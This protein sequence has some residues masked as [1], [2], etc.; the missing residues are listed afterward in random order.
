MHIRKLVTDLQSQGLRADSKFL[1]RNGG[2]GPAQGKFFDLNGVAVN[3]PMAGPYISNSE[4]YLRYH[5]DQ[6]AIVQQGRE[7]GLIKEIP[8]PG[9]YDYQTQEGIAYNKIALLHGRDCLASTVEQTCRHWLQDKQCAFCAIQTSLACN[10][11]TATKTPAQLA[12]VAQAAQALDEVTHVVL[13]TGAGNPAGNEI[14]QLI[15]AVQAVKASTM[16]P[17][18]VQFL[19]PADLSLL[20][21][22]KAV[23]VDTVG[24]HIES[25]DLHTLHR[26]AP[27]KAEIGFNRY[28]SAWQKAVHVFGANQVSSFLLVGLGEPAQSVVE[29]SEFLAGLGVY[30]FVVPF[31][32]IAG[33]GLQDRQP[34]AAELMSQIYECVAGILH[35][36][37]LNSR[38]SKA[39]CVR[40][41]ACSALHWYELGQDMGIVCHRARNERELQEAYAIRRQVFVSEQ[42]LFPESDQDLEDGY[43]IHLVAQK[44]ERIVG[45]VRVTPKGDGLWQGS[46]LAVSKESRDSHAGRLLVK[47][48]MRTVKQYNATKFIANIQ[49]PNV[50][51]FRRLGWKPVGPVQEYYGIAHQLMEADLAK[52]ETSLPEAQALQK[53]SNLQG[54]LSLS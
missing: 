39:G 38:L 36:K 9:F 26:L 42:A 44:K 53:G 2:A 51:F 28:E 21:E 23:G 22:L 1:G 8:R 18:H 31:R 50:S 15:K 49:Q 4:Y 27:A 29:G 43:S 48:A 32:P 25:F 33:S 13:T 16:L 52:V 3:I 20:D 34:P 10:Q 12:E 41:G 6:L 35:S 24:I 17:I 37:G 11:T 7:L 54:A 19:P 46:R 40:C 30:P 5:A 47:E 45:T 14:M